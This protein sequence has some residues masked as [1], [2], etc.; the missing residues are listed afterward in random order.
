MTDSLNQLISASLLPLRKQC[1]SRERAEE[2]L[3]ARALHDEDP[4]KYWA[5]VAGQQRWIRPWTTLRSGGLT[6]FRY[7]EGGLINVADNCVDR[8]A[9]DAT[10]ADTAAIIWEG[11]PGDSR[12]VTYRELAAEVSSLAAGLLDL[13]VTKGDVVAI[14]M[15]NLVE[16]FTA[17]HA[18]N[19]IGA[20]YTVLFSGFGADAVVSRL[21]ASAAK[22]VVVADASYRRGKLVPLLDN[23]RTARRNLDHVA[24][25]IVVDRTGRQVPLQRGEVSYAELVSAHPG[26]TPVVPLE[27]NDAAFLIFT[28]GTEATPKGVVH[29]VGGFLVGTWAN[30]HWQVGRE[31]GDVYWVAADVGWLTFPIQA[32]VGG[33]A[34]GMT[35]ACYEGALDTPTNE[36]FYEFVERHGVTKVLAAP[37]VLRMLRK[38]GDELCARHP[39]P[40]LKLVTVQGEPL[41]AD[42]F[43]W[44]SEH[45]AGGVPI[46]NAYG[47]TETGSTWTY[48]V[49][50]VDDLKAGSVGRPLPGHECVVVDDNGE[51]VP[52]GTK[53]NLLLTRPFPTLARTVWGNHDRYL[54]TYFGRFP[55]R[56]ATNDEAVFDSDGHLWVLGRADDVINVAAHRIST[57][58][59]EAVVTAHDQVTEA[60]VIGVPDDTKGTVPIA[61]VTL[62]AGADAD[63]VRADLIRLTGEELG[64]YARL[65]RVYPTATLPKTRTGK[66]MRRLLRDVL[67]TGRPEGDTSAMEDPAALSAVV[68]AIAGSAAAR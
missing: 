25:T 51:P 19:R 23:L 5:W 48:P 6:D 3:A 10:A 13:G 38:F 47:Q 30:A 7:F 45:L 55:G 63:A 39:L 60:A 54:S 41:D 59:I 21:R 27:P 11:E 20:I 17:I 56:Y 57:M 35:I 64:G 67:V 16:A 66:I 32:V 36:R 9:E 61:F 58:E 34:C 31:P 50:G 37:T 14:Y 43:G 26:G 65:A 40:Q 29:S 28:S 46:V 2:L 22:A 12:T 62:M 52:P 42:T 24:H 18:C 53:G 15:P 49:A 1:Y 8:W 44:A 68:T 4:D 33:L